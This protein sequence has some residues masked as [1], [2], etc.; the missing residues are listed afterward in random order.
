MKNKKKIMIAVIALIV[1]ITAFI[2]ALKSC[3]N[4]RDDTH[5]DE[6]KIEI[7][8]TATTAQ[9]TTA[10]G[11]TEPVVTTTEEVVTTA[12]ET[13]EPTELTTEATE[14]A[15]E[16]TQPKPTEPK[17]TE[18]KPAEPKPTEPKPTEP[19]PQPTEPKPTEPAAQPTEPKPTEPDPTDPPANYNTAWGTR[20]YEFQEIYHDNFWGPY[21][22]HMD[23]YGNVWWDTTNG[24]SSA[25]GKY[26]YEGCILH[27][28][29]TVHYY[30]NGRWTG[31]GYC[32][33]SD[34]F[35]SGS[36]CPGYFLARSDWGSSYESYSLPGD[37]PRDYNG[38]LSYF[39]AYDNYDAYA[40]SGIDVSVELPDGTIVTQE[41][42]DNVV[43]GGFVFP[44]SP[45][46]G[47]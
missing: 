30:G 37:M 36:Y 7:A 11:S 12:V 34:G 17:P 28:T 38:I 32:W 44:Y 16:E 23:R 20:P 18:S 2:L 24:Y 9:E 31:N 33:D 25:S 13:T 39:N 42:Y 29:S 15:T 47:R 3:N 10:A 46:T 43:N 26:I 22:F 5:I 21:V 8:I 4:G 14:P 1:I 41:M 35:M 40:S 27:N 6:T 19:K 45:Y